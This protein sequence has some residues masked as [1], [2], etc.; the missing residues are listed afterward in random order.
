MKFNL[1]DMRYFAEKHRGKYCTSGPYWSTIIR[2][3]LLFD[4]YEKAITRA[5]AA[6][7]RVADLERIIRGMFPLWLAAMGYCEHGKHSELLAMRNYYNGRDNPMTS[8]DI[9]LMLSLIQEKGDEG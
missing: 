9:H 7:S 3:P 6:E 4:E 8:D 1:E 2:F 5:E